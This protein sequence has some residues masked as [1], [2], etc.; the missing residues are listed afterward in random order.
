MKRFLWLLIP[1]AALAQTE[2]PE[3]EMHIFDQDA[4]VSNQD[5]TLRMVVY[6]EPRTQRRATEQQTLYLNYPEENQVEVY[7]EQS[8]EAG[9]EPAG[10]Y[11]MDIYLDVGY[12][13]DSLQWTIADRDNNP[14]ILS[15]LKWDNLDIALIEAG[16]R[17]TLPS[18][19][20]IDGRFAYGTIVDGK[21][22]DSDYNGN[23][24]TQEF[25]RSNNLADDGNTLDA[26]LALG[27]RFPVFPARHGKPWWSI[28]PEVGFSYHVQNLKIR[29]GYQTIPATGY[30]GGLD[31]S[32]DASWYGPWAGV[33]SEVNIS[34]WV[35]LN[36][37]FEYHYAYYNATANWNLRTDFQ[38]PKSFEHEAEGTGIVASAGGQ[39][40]I[41]PKLRLQFSVD[42][43]NWKANQKG[44]DTTYFSS[45][46]VSETRLNEVN[47]DSLGAN[48]GLRYAF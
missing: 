30:F 28:T 44:I 20:V 11:E 35:S 18:R 27:Y 42:Y 9:D 34:D 43:Q 5:D 41:N 8:A 16:S 12:R 37:S 25:S 36:A 14:N 10:K 17:L 48:I 39:I 31:S 2:L 4:P 29:R 45:G 40:R 15:E 32:Y 21:N 13:Q 19:W 6:P 38:H 7:S 1:G 46:T 23:D 22:Q 33:D 26:S 47:W 24:R 3:M